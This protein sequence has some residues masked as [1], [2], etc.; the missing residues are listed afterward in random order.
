MTRASGRTRFARGARKLCIVGITVLITAGLSAAIVYALGWP[1][2]IQLPQSD[3]VREW[4]GADLAASSSGVIAAWANSTAGSGIRLA[5]QQDGTLS[6]MHLADPLFGYTW[7]PT[8]AAWG[9]HIAATW[10]QGQQNGT[11]GTPFAIMQ[12]DVGTPGATSLGTYYGA[13]TAPDIAAGGSGWH[14]VFAAATSEANC[15]ASKVDLYYSYRTAVGQPWSPPVVLVTHNQVLGAGA[16]SGGIWYPRVAASPTGSAVYI[17]WEQYQI[18]GTPASVDT[19]VWSISTATLNAEA[20]ASAA[21]WAAAERISP[22]GQRYAAR[23]RVAADASSRAHIV[24]TELV[25]SRTNPSEQHI[26]HVSLPGGAAIQLNNEPI[27]VT[28]NS[29]AIVGSSVDALEQNVCVTWHGYTGL[30]GTGHEQITLRCSADAGGAWTPEDVVSTSPDALSIYP[31]VGLAGDGK[32]HVA[33]LKYAL[34]NDAWK[35][36]GVF[37]RG[38][39]LDQDDNRVFLPLVLRG[40]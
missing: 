26:Y 5:L 12:Q 22:V 13:A 32:V 11:C 6:S 15:L 37:Y 28:S 4:D 33:W 3:G 17:V 14:I 2:A 10:A 7:S 35:P 31:A 34:E 23:P 39:S 38:G 20:T 19:S 9:T 36:Q 40:R 25:G 18:A 1:A 27:H 16:S 30:G 21:T 24:W 8:L 29:P